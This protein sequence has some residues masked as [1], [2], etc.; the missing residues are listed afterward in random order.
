M[1]SHHSI[2]LRSDR[3]FP[4]EHTEQKQGWVT[5]TE[6]DEAA[7]D[8]KDLR[9]AECQTV[10]HAVCKNNLFFFYTTGDKHASVLEDASQN[11]NYT[12]H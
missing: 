12:N 8:Q 4:Q 2:Y 11:P 7:K 3:A 10:I 1:K 9:K 6:W 5:E